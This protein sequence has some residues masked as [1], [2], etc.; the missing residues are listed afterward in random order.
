MFARRKGIYFRIIHQPD[1]LFLMNLYASTREWEFA[2]TVWPEDEKKDFLKRQFEAQKLHYERLFPNAVC[3]II[4][5]DNVD[6][7]RL[8]L[9]KEDECLRI[10][11]MSL[12]PTYQR[13]GIG[14]DILRSLL[15]EASGGK[16]PVRLKVEKDSPARHLY[17]RH[18]FVSTGLY[19]HHLSLEWQP[20]RCSLEI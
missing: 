15:N 18:H 7:G 16:V 4:V 14:T 6:I 9:N 1:N 11:E 2:L 13:R 19:G 17:L 3:R 10:I 12:L 5:L 20:D 8:Y